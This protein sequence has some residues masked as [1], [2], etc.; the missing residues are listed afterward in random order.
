MTRPWLT[1]RL[2]LLKLGRSPTKPPRVPRYLL[3]PYTV[4]FIWV[5]CSVDLR[6]PALVKALGFEQDSLV[7]LFTHSKHSMFIQMQFR[8]L[9]E[10]LLSGRGPVLIKVFNA[11][12]EALVCLGGGRQEV[13]TQSTKRPSAGRMD[14]PSFLHDKSAPAYQPYTFSLLSWS[15]ILL[16]SLCFPPA[17]CVRLMLC[18]KFQKASLGGSTTGNRPIYWCTGLKGEPERTCF[19]WVFFFKRIVLTL[20]SVMFSIWY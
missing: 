8:G 16:P 10:V 11:R 4:Y 14:L 9:S 20:H 17:T 5:Q 13:D 6:G 12:V 1:W 2:H 3:I 15:P 18:N 7:A 19:C